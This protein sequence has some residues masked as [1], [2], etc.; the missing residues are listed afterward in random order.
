MIYLEKFGSA[1]EKTK[2]KWGIP[3][4]WWLKAPCFGSQHLSATAIFSLLT[5]MQDSD[6][7]LTL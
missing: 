6:P 4:H 2:F 3:F 1:E 7:S 5:T